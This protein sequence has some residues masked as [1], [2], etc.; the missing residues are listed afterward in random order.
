MEDFR[1]SARVLADPRTPATL[2]MG[3]LAKAMTDAEISAAAESFGA[4]NWTP[5]VRGIETAPVP[6]TRIAGNLFLAIEHA[7]AEPLAGRILERPENEAQAEGLRS[8]RSGLVPGVSVGG[9]KKGKNLL[10]TGGMT[11]VDG[12]IVPGKTVA[13]ATCHGPD[14]MGL[15]DVPGIAGRCPS[16][17]VR[18]L[19]DRQQGA[20]R[21]PSAPLMLPVVAQL[22]G[23]DLFAIAAY[24]MSLVPPAVESGDGRKR[25]GEID[26]RSSAY[27]QRRGDRGFAV[28]RNSRD[29]NQNPP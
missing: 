14:L 4:M 2:T 13:C 17:S 8:P 28:S 26:G 23:D 22:T 1:R 11:V 12:E 10:T 6:R 15:A 18:Q 3:V 9:I 29:E 16:Y 21:G 7:R 5:W 25:F 24:V 19:H 20:R 27:L